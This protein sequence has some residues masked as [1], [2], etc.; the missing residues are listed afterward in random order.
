MNALVE[1]YRARFGSENMPPLF[2]MD[3]E[4]AQQLLG[5]ALLDGKELTPDRLKELGYKAPSDDVMI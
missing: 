2:G 1:A 5:R 3:P 4:Q